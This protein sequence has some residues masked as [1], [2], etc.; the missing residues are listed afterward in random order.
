MRGAPQ[1]VKAGPLGADPKEA[2]IPGF[3]GK[4]AGIGPCATRG[5]GQSARGVE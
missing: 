1:A 2:T 3:A 5:D 4:T